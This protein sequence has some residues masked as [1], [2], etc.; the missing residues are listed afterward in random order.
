MPYLRRKQLPGEQKID[1][2]RAAGKY[3]GDCALEQQADSETCRQQKCPQARM[4]LL[5]VQH[6]QECPHGERNCGRQ[7]H[8][9]NQDP[10]KQEQS[11]A[12]RDCE[13]RVKPG[14]PAERP[15]AESRG[16]PP[17]RYAR[18]RYG[19]ARGPIEGAE[20]LVGDGNQ[21]VNQR[22]F[23]EINNAVDA[24]RDPIARGQHIAGDLRLHGVHI[25]HQRRRG[26]NATQ[27]N[28][29]GHQGDSQVD[30]NMLAGTGRAA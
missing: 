22:R 11:D 6:A 7:H 30:V 1:E 4:G 21:P 5:F 12:R 18:K 2:R 10:R 28:R 8:V 3:Q 20:N 23:F 14:A 9:R 29:R 17:Q 13:A 26:E 15:R 24:R 19:Y 16:Q 27:I 25:V